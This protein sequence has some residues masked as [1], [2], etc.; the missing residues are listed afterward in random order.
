MFESDV[1]AAVCREDGEG[2]VLVTVRH[3]L[4]DGI[5]D[6]NGEPLSPEAREARSVLTWRVPFDAHHQVSRDELASVLSGVGRN[7]APGLMWD[8]HV[9]GVLSD[10]AYLE[11]AGA[12]S[13]AEFPLNTLDGEAWV[14]LFDA[15][16][17]TV[18]GEPAVR[19]SGPLRLYRGAVDE[20]ARGWSWTDDLAVA[21]KFASG[22]LWRSVGLVGRVWVATV[23]PWD[24]L[25]RITDRQEAEYVVDP[26]RL[27]VEP[28]PDGDEQ[29]L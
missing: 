23:E 13:M 1:T 22:E 25:A 14:E 26:Y 21:R 5:R 3:E 10:D 19:P 11:T 8:L 15:A 12:W 7:L 29:T 6:V 20:S 16:G 4:P 18:D 28:L 2:F 17:Y 9:L 24:L 27:A